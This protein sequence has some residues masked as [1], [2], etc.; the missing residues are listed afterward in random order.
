MARENYRYVGYVSSLMYFTISKLS[1]INYVYQFSLEKFI[2]D[3][4]IVLVEIKENKNDFS[5]TIKDKIT[6][7]DINFRKRIYK[8]C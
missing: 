4:E 6:K 8:T 2:L 3:F 5:N 7:I 1:K